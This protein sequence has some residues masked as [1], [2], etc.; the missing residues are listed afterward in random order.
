MFGAVDDL[1]NAVQKLLADEPCGDVERMVRIAEQVEFLK[2]R[3]IAAFER[4]GDCAA[5]G[6]VSTAAALRAKCRMVP[7]AA[8]R[9]IV[10]ARKLEALPE[11]SAAIGSGEMSRHHAAITDSTH[12]TGT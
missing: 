4:S 11:T 9:S 12:T 10:L 1:D 5:E 6:F 7:G 8:H 3:E 2:L